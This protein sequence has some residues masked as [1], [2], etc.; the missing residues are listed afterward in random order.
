L[1]IKAATIQAMNKLIPESGC[2]FALIDA[3]KVDFQKSNSIIKGD[4]LSITIAAASILAKVTRDRIM[5]ELDKTYPLYCF[6]SNKG[7][8]TSTHIHALEKNGIIE[9]VHRVSYAP[10]KNIINKTKTK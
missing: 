1:N 10:I 6:K 7:Y 9:K 3:E 4:A 2:D 5:I 8:G